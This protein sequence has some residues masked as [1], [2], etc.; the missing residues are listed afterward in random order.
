MTQYDTDPNRLLCH[1]TQG[2]QGTQDTKNP[3]Y[4]YTKIPATSTAY[5]V[6]RTAYSVDKHCKCIA[7]QTIK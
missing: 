6:Q 5:S 7:K 4:I 3:I 1:S 2:T